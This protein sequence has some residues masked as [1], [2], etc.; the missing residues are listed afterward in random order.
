MRREWAHLGSNQLGRYDLVGPYRTWA[1]SI[2]SRSTLSDVIRPLAPVESDT[3]S[4]TAIALAGSQT[5]AIS[6]TPE[7]AD[8]VRSAQQTG[9]TTRPVPSCPGAGP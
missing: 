1:R 8:A 5:E 4:D 2:W 7:L 6:V 9:P 3:G